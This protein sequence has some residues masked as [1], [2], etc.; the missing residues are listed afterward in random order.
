MTDDGMEGQS[1][2]PVWGA[3]EEDANIRLR[4]EL[5][6]AVEREVRFRGLT[7]ANAVERLGVTQ[8]RPE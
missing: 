4:P 5:L 3:I 2:D 6:T 1:F 7:Q 8:P